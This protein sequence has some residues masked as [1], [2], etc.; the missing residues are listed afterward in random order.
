MAGEMTSRE[1][2]LAAIECREVDYV[3]CSF[4]IFAALRSRCESDEE[5]VRRQVAMGL[6]AVVPTASWASARNPEH[7]DLPG[8][9]LP[10]PPQVQVR[11]WRE[12]RSGETDVL[13]KE[14][15]TPDGTLK[16]EVLATDDWPYPNHVPI[17][18]DYL[19]PRAIRF[20][21][22][23]RADL[24]ALRH[25]LAPPEPKDVARFRA[26]AAL[27]QELSKELDLLLSGGMG[28]GLEAGAWLCG[29]EE[30]IFH[31]VDRPEMVDELA[32]MLHEWN[33]TRMKEVL[34]IG[35]D[36]FV[37]RGWY[38]GTD[39]WS[40]P[41]YRRFILP[42]L[43]REVE[44]AHEAGTKF[45]YINTSG[46]MG[47]LDCL[48]EAGVDVLIGVDPVEGARTDMRAMR[49][50]VGE[51]MGLWG[52]V[53][54]FV[55]VEMGSEQEIRDAVREAIEALGPRG[56]ILSPVDN[57]RDESDE[58]MRRVQVFIDAWREMR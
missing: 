50:R 42:Y 40:P 21:V 25:L 2:M 31:A 14:Y 30:L 10:F 16:T 22:E 28:L 8:I 55:T 4:M 17:F 13:H 54:G 41:M 53:N 1:R 34:A 20:P 47:I 43:K 35:V 33:V 48:L 36:L 7:R 11:Q 15:A 23:S 52:G 38:E 58:T 29:M 57:I 51:R 56:L 45:G 32:E 6:D 49:E 9:D 26:N 18:D 44:L 46:T 39:F 19:V 3:P 37:R 12:E 27:A 24:A 5:F